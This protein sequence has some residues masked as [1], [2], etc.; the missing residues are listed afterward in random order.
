MMMKGGDHIAWVIMAKGSKG[1]GRNNNN[2]KAQLKVQEQQET[3]TQRR[4]NRRARKITRSPFVNTTLKH[5]E[6]WTTISFIQN[7]EQGEDGGIKKYSFAS[8]TYPPWF[9]EIAKL[10]EMYQ[11]H[12]VRIYT[13][14][15]AATTT[16]GSYILSYNTNKAQ[17]DSVRTADQ[18]AGQQ[19]A[20]QANV[21]KNLSVIIPASA[22]KNFRTNTPCQGEESWAFNL[23]MAMLGNSTALNVPVWIE[24]T[25]SLRN[26]QV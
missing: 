9:N 2:S 12:Y 7:A 14:S 19:N 5:R 25:V 11:L 21:F 1:K 13:A 3:K 26:P 17:V 20:K 6:L 23:E 22:L 15:Y 24:Y 10:Y 16:N 4:R 8:G 18:L